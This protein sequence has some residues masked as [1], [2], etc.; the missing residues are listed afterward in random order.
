MGSGIDWANL[1]LYNAKDEQTQI[2]NAQLIAHAPEMLEAL[3]ECKEWVEN[4]NQYA[5]IVKRLDDL[6]TRATTI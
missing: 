6:L 3:I 2:A 1:T 5:P 4:C